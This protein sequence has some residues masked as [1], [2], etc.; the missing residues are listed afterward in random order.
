MQ[1][2]PQEHH[3]AYFANCRFCYFAN[4]LTVNFMKTFCVTF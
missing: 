1:L 2:L 4:G 3:V